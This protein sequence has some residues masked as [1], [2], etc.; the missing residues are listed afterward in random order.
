MT[1]KGVHMGP[2]LHLYFMLS[3]PIYRKEKINMKKRLGKR[4]ATT[5]HS[6]QAYQACPCRCMAG[7]GSQPYFWDHQR[8]VA[9]DGGDFNRVLLTSGFDPRPP[10]DPLL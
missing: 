7:C 10:L 1:A 4:N 9:V 8:W 6:L 2:M 5:G 3:N